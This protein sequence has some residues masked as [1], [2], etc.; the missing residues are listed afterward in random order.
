MAFSSGQNVVFR[1]DAVQNPQDMMNSSVRFTT[2]KMP[3]RPATR[4]RVRSN[5]TRLPLFASINVA[6]GTLLDLGV[7]S[8]MLQNPVTAH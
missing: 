3:T 5:K 4:T 7:E 2:V 1:T 8:R 6:T